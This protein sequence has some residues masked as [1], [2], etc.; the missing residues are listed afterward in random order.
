MNIKPPLKL[1]IGSCKILETPC[2]PNFD[3]PEWVIPEMF[4]ILRH[5]NGAGL[6]APQV[7][8][9]ARLFVTAWGI[10]YINPVITWK[11]DRLK[12]S[13]EKCLSFPNI[14][15]EL[16]RHLQIEIGGKSYDGEQAVILQHEIDHLNGFHIA[17]RSKWGLRKTHER[18]HHP[19]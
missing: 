16:P 1:V 15:I 10:V 13:S 18:K 2:F 8:I 12:W 17:M 11:S 3:I 6:A 5:Q 14:T 9:N 7:G 4:K 19:L